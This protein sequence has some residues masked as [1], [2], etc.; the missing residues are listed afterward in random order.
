M[1]WGLRPVFTTELGEIIGVVNESI[2]R[3]AVG[4]VERWAKNQDP[5]WIKS[6]SIIQHFEVV[7]CTIE[8]LPPNIKVSNF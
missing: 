4:H 7:N 8:L 5:R 1:I 2:I 3:R 6:T